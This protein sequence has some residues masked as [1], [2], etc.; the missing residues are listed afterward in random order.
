MFAVTANNNGAWQT[1]AQVL[2]LAVA[3]HQAQGAEAEAEDADE[4][5]RVE[6]HKG[7]AGAAVVA[8]EAPHLHQ[9]D[10]QPAAAGTLALNFDL[11]LTTSACI[12]EI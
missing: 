11:G 10:V 2:A 4:L 12:L 5:L 7:A 8:L 6:E 3:V 1:S 9:I